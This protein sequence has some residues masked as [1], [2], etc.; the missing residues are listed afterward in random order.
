MLRKKAAASIA[1]M[2]C[3]SAS[4]ASIFSPTDETINFI[5]YYSTTP[6]EIGIF[7]DSDP[8]YTGDYLSVD[9]AG[10]NV[11][12]TPSGSD[13]II[14]NTSS[15]SPDSFTLTDSD[16]FTLAAWS[17]TSGS[18]LAPDAV[19]CSAASNSCVLSWSGLLT[20][21]AVDLIEA[22]PPDA[23]VPLPPSALL[24]GFGLFGLTVVA[25][26]RK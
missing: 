17:M 16:Q 19:T 26:R 5:E 4:A 1:A 7:D 11:T 13:Y 6:V 15:S 21:L 23:A 3:S 2:L 14:T 8:T 22:T 25:R 10:D 9:A 20:E 12:F 18:W 24:F